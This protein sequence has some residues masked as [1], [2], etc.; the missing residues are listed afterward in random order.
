MLVDLVVL[1]RVR[2]EDAW[3]AHLLARH[4]ILPSVRYTLALLG[5]AQVLAENN[6]LKPISAGEVL[7]RVEEKTDMSQSPQNNTDSDPKS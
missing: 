5:H 1:R 6:S 2:H 7:E 4:E 3:A